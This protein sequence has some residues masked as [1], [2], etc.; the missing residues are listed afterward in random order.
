MLTW[1]IFAGPVTYIYVH[2]I[3]TFITEALCGCTRERAGACVCMRVCVSVSVCAYVSVCQ[4]VCVCLSACL[5]VCV[6][7]EANVLC[8]CVPS[9]LTITLHVHYYWH[10]VLG[11]QLPFNE[12]HSFCYILMFY[13]DFWWSLNIPFSFEQK[14]SC[15]KYS[16][17]SLVALYNFVK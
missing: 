13:R 4:S 1:L 7:L 17:L 16:A 11:N 6:I 15:Q 8:V 12:V 10:Y 5:W 9:D 14:S 2:V 3:P